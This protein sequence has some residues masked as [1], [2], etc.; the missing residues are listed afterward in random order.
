M[1][2]SIPLRAALVGAAL[3]CFPAAV[4]AA[5]TGISYT[6][7]VR[8]ILS[9][10]CFKCHGPDDDNRKADF[11]LDLREAALMNLGGYAAI[12]PGSPEKSKLLEFVTTDDPDERMPP[13]KGNNRRLKPEE[14]A[15]LRQWIA[16]GAPYETHWAYRAPERPKLPPL[17]NA[18]PA[19]AGDSIDAFVR[20]R[21]EREALSL[22]PA[23]EPAVLLRRVHLDLTGLPPTVAQVEAFVR[24]PSPAAYARVVDDLLASPHY[25]ERWARLWLDLARYADT[26]GFQHDRTRTIWPYRDWVVNALNADMPFDRFTIEQLAG[27]LLPGAT[28]EQKV[29]TGF[30]RAAAVNLSGDTKAEDTRVSIAHDRVHTTSTVWLGSTM[31]CAQCHTHKFDPITIKDYYS[32][33]AFFDSAADEVLVTGSQGRK[34]RLFGGLM[35]KPGYPDDEHSVAAI[36]KRIVEM[37]APMLEAEEIMLG[38]REAPAGSTVDYPARFENLLERL[39]GVRK[40][41]DDR[42]ALLVPVMEEAPVQR[43]TFVHLRGDR[44]TP[45][46]RVVPAT[47]EALPPMPPS[48]EPAR[49]RLARWL[50][51]RENPLTARVTVN[52]WWNEI[53]GRGLVTTTEDFGHQ[54]ELPSHRELLDWLAVEFMEGGWSMKRLHRLIML[55]ETY[56]QSAVVTP[57]LLERDPDNILLARGPRF[58]LTAEAI[59]DHALAVSGLLK[60]TLGGQPV[61]PPQPPGLWR[62]V[63]IDEKDYPT[64]TTDEQYR[65]SLYVFWRRSS[66]YPSFLAFDAP[67]RAVC[68]TRRGRS[69]TPLQALVLLNDPVYL[70]AAVAFAAEVLRAPGTAGDEARIRYAFHR[71]L[72]RAPRAEETARLQRLLADKRAFFSQQPEAARELVAV[73]PSAADHPSPGELAATFYVTHTLLNLDE[74]V[75][76]P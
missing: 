48:D 63:N 50:V 53:F 6:R 11:R 14:V 51:S 61:F 39:E 44:R 66:A 31:E 28:W 43:E 62:E 35:Q 16:E 30:N 64:T 5:Q 41:F 23:A 7:D 46:A 36:Q 38:Q 60:P 12:V 49:L 19:R 15:V 74:C 8:P 37:S 40:V 34:K 65:R 3:A 4:R 9:N 1:R 56:R 27:D 22:S 47:P 20:A 68:A 54:G 75:T 42:A 57:A 32:F 71:A 25:G 73:L 29:A 2:R 10:A 33:M 13:L 72:A 18:A 59:R 26:N 55:S 70:Q 67:T 24:D 21:L 76:K 58:R 69:N 45:G 17:A 52:R